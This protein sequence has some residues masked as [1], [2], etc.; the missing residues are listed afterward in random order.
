MKP[1]ILH[2]SDPKVAALTMDLSAMQRWEVLRRSETPMTAEQLATA[3]RTTIPIAQFT[4]DRLVDAG[5]AVRLKASAT[6]RRITYRSVG[7]HVLVQYDPTSPPERALVWDAREAT[8]QYGRKVI[9]RAHAAPTIRSKSLRW[10]DVDCTPILTYEE[11][12]EALELLATTAE[13]L[14]EIES[15]AY[16]RALADPASNALSRT[17]GYYVQLLLQPLEEPELPLPS[18]SV[19]SRES[20]AHEVKRLSKAPGNVLSLREQEIARRLAAGESRPTIAHALRLSP[21]TVAATCKRV[22]AKLGVH[23]RAELASR[24]LGP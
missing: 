16:K 15:R 9:D 23:S 24:M 2:L 3:C 12:M 13:K 5:F 10:L 1:V 19:W 21:H 4:L 18:Y 22:Y 7:E 20:I 17:R 6:R 14:K 8:K 11:S